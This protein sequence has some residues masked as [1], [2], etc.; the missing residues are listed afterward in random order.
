MGTEIIPVRKP[1]CQYVGHILVHKAHRD[2]ALDQVTQHMRHT[3]TRMSRHMTHFHSAPL[4]TQRWS[5][6][7]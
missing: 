1:V 3:D 4:N 7:Y 6:R 5:K 2:Q